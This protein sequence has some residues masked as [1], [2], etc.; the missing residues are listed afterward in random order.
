MAE[1]MN[2]ATLR[3]TLRSPEALRQQPFGILQS[4]SCLVG[5][6]EQELVAHEM[7]LRALEHRQHFGPYQ[8][9]LDSLVRSAG[10][11]P[12]LEP[13]TLSFRD[14]IAYEFHRPDNMGEEFV[15]HREQGESTG[16]FSPV[17]A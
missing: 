15:F 3:D 12:Y 2:I 4:I 1:A 8:E 7:V 14:A 9:V 5:D 17:T 10:L 6:P 11:F 13:D 16:D